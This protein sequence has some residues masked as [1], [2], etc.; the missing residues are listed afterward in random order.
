[1]D[2]KGC[3]V[4]VCVHLDPTLRYSVAS[5][6]AA[7]SSHQIV[8]AEPSDEFFGGAGPGVHVPLKIVIRE[9]LGQIDGARAVLLETLDRTPDAAE[10]RER[11][12]RLPRD[13]RGPSTP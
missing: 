11:L 12:K 1:M 13:P 2:V 9:R 5:A 8:H 3:L 10:L 6:M 4:Q 7:S